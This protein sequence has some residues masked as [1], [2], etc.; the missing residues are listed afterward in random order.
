MKSHKPKTH[1][2]RQNLLAWLILAALFCHSASA[3]DARAR[4]AET[5][6][7]SPQTTNAPTSNAQTT[8][9]NQTSA[10][11]AVAPP[12]FTGATRT[13]TELQ[14]RLRDVVNQTSLNSAIIAVKVVSIDS[15]RT[16]FEANAEKLLNPASNM[17]LYTFAAALDR[18][19]PDFR[20]KTSVYA[21]SRPDAQGVIHGDLVIYGRG[22]PSFA[23]RF[24]SG[25]Y[26]KAIDDLAAQIRQAGVKRIEGDIIGDESYFSGAP[27]GR[28]WEWDDLQWYYG[29]EISALTVND[30]SLDIFIKPGARIGDL[31]AISFGPAQFNPPLLQ[32]NNSLT[33]APRGA[34]RELTIYRQPGTN[35][36][37][38][39]GALALDD[40]GYQA[41]VAV[42]HPAMLFTEM[43]RAALERQGA[44]IT[45]RTRTVDCEA[46]AVCM[47]N[48]SPLA[49]SL[50]L[51]AAPVEIA[52]RLSPP[53][54]EIAAKT[55]KPSQ[56]LYTEL[57]LRA[58]GEQTRQATASAIP[59]FNEQFRTSAE[60]GID[61]VK[62]FLRAAN[63]NADD[64]IINDGSG[65]S[66]GDFVTADAT[67]KLLVLMNRHRYAQVFYDALPV[68]GVDGT[69]RNRLKGTAAAGNVHAKTG[70]LSNSTALSGY[71]RSATGENFAFS[72]IINNFSSEADTKRNGTDAV[73]ALIASFGGHS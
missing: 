35:V 56:N 24:T 29:A 52:A 40:A 33:T 59:A 34:K 21:A 58:L 71:V 50:P 46:R 70:T 11:S 18:L 15:G 3:Q 13:L 2:A 51:A 72:V 22:D 63:I 8:Q 5:A 4:R 69:L 16:V 62:S 38:V 49:R 31:C 9:P 55:L 53:L 57:V 25:D 30:N 32:V 61:A 65:L 66:R 44:Q 39:S 7:A 10:S 68:A 47:A 67:V 48:K 14:A 12:I 41:S 17:K 36:L 1:R 64:L 54:S 37:Q 60:V 28:G 27:L 19:T 43:L 20:F 23:T 42:P 6:P 45:G 26:Y 73:A